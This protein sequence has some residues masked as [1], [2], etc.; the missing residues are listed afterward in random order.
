MKISARQYAQSLYELVEG[1]NEIKVTELL[2]NFVVVLGHKRDLNLVP[3]I[4]STFTDIWNRENGE[5]TAELTLARELGTE[6][7]D[8]VVDYL[9]KKSGAKDVILTE[10]VDKKILGGFILKY[11]SKIVDGSLRNSLSE[12]KSEMRG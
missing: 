12:L 10:K 3:A 1:E 2:H 11:N 5:V 7:R 6:A 8:I 9:I 4:V